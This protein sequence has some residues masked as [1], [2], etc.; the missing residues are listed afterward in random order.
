MPVSMTKTANKR[1]NAN[2]SKYAFIPKQQKIFSRSRAAFAQFYAT[3][4]VH[5]GFDDENSQ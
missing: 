1:K 4:A 3:A 5:T 2:L